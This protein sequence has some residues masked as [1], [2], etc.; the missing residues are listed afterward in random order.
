MLKFL[1]KYNKI[2]LVVGGCLLMIVFLVPQALTQ[3]SFS[4]AGRTVAT[5]DGGSFNERDYHNAAGEIQ[6]IASVLGEGGLRMLG[7]DPG[8]RNA[9]PHWL[10]LVREAERA[11]FV[12]GPSSGVEAIPLLAQQQARAML[13]QQQAEQQTAE[14]LNLFAS[15]F[16]GQMSDAREALGSRFGAQTV[17]S[18]LAKAMG[19]LRM[20]MAYSASARLSGPEARLVA[21]DNLYAVDIDLIIL[22]ATLLLDSLDDPS[23]EEIV[24]QYEQYRETQPG[25]GADEFGY[26]QPPRVKVEWITVDRQRIARAANPDP[27]EMRKRWQENRADFPGEFVQERARIEAELRNEAVDNAIRAAEQAVRAAVASDVRDLPISSGRW[28]QV[29]PDWRERLATLEKIASEIADQIEQRVGERIEPIVQ[30]RNEWM[31]YSQLAE[32]PNIGS[33]AYRIGIS[34]QPFASMVFEVFEANPSGARLA[35]VGVPF[36]PLTDDN[37]NLH[38]VRFTDARP[39]GPPDDLA[40]VRD[41]VVLDLKRKRAYEMLLARIEEFRRR[42]ISEG[43]ASLTQEFEEAFIRPG[44]VT[45]RAPNSATAPRG[46]EAD[47]RNAIVDAALRLDPTK[48]VELAPREQRI[49]AQ[50]MPSSMSIALVEIKGLEPLTIEEYRSFGPQIPYMAMSYTAYSPEEDPFSFE[51]L[52]RRHNFVDLNPFEEETDAADAGGA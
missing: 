40:M 32:L 47:F 21:A 35:Q 22:S 6:I 36:G 50:P 41:R 51:N 8:S 34:N 11:G 28:R 9:R 26:L 3:T 13:A 23:E 25:D 37:G 52:T 2:I 29:P 10:L 17:D 46:D 27:I 24:A 44:L 39:I 15:F 45:R 18:A 4:G 49:I 31:N 12:G 7:L 5:F 48:S 33:A 43:V 38:F 42:G 1:R 20:T 16:T 19:V 14:M 30:R